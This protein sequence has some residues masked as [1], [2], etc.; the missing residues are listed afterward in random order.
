MQIVVT[1]PRADPSHAHLAALQI[2]KAATVAV[3]PGAP[4]APPSAAAFLLRV[5][6][7]H[8]HHQLNVSVEPTDTVAVLKAKIYALQG[9]NTG[10]ASTPNY[11]SV[12]QSRLFSF[13]SR[14]DIVRCSIWQALAVKLVFVDLISLPVCQRKQKILKGV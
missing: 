3:A 14:D 12:S 1:L 10:P 8:R 4:F 7:R 2:G 11:S 9:A 13:Y 5:N 6:D